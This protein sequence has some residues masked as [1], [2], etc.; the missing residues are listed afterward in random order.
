MLSFENEIEA[1]RDLIGANAGS[2]LARERREVF[3]LHHELRLLAWG[4]ASLLAAAA[5]TFIA[6][7]HER[8]GPLAI[9][10]LIGLAA[11]ACYAFAWWR[12]DR[13]SMIDDYVLL[14]GALL[15]SAD[16]GFIESQFHLFEQSWTR[17]FLI[18]ALVHAIAA[19]KFDSRMVLTLSITALAAWFGVRS[20]VMDYSS[21]AQAMRF[22]AAAAAVLIWTLLDRR[23]RPSRSFDR[24]FEHF[25]ANLA[26]VGA[27]MVVTDDAT[28]WIGVLVAMAFA[29]A[30]I[31]WGVRTDSEP[32]VL[33]AII[34][35][36]FA[37]D[38]LFFGI[39]D[40]EAFRLLFAMMSVIG[41]LVVLFVVHARFRRLE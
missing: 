13:A 26:L 27:M 20:E 22:F 4:G 37:V 2:L 32:F 19:Y 17:H 24:T 3:S 36:V 38:R 29:A 14:L 12:R 33:Y 21:G 8:I 10:I 40:E 7:N 28:M 6:R 35:A 18:L 5:A 30:V 16:V 15:V 25:A 23:F 1:S 41:A 31:Y 11:A 9:A 34:Y 39:V